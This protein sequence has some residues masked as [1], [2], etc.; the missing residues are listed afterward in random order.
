MLLQIAFNSDN[1]EFAV[2]ET[3]FSRT[4]N[5]NLFASTEKIRGK[6][7]LLSLKL[8]TQK[9]CIILEYLKKYKMMT[10]L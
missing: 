9:I 1:L 7:M 3:K 2:S 4:N 8:K 6:F 10:N 5:T